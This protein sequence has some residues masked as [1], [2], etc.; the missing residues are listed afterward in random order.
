M[1]IVVI[2]FQPTQIKQ[3]VKNLLVFIMYV[4]NAFLFLILHT[5]I[6]HMDGN[7]FII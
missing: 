6:E 1:S 4:S 7:F 5:V 2:K 3:Q